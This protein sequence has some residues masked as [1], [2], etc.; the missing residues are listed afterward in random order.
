MVPK[1]PNF[2]VHTYLQ[3][4]LDL[5][6]L[7]PS[8]ENSTTGIAMSNHFLMLMSDVWGHF[9]AI[10]VSCGANGEFHFSN[11]APYLFST[12]G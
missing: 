11:L 3:K 2:V 5:S 6:N 10:N 9:S 12:C 1:P 4:A 8:L 7:Y